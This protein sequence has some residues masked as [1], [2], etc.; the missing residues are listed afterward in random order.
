MCVCVCLGNV[1]EKKNCRVCSIA[2]VTIILVAHACIAVRNLTTNFVLFYETVF[3]II[4][5]A[6]KNMG[7]NFILHNFRDT[8]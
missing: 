4:Y 5:K 7:T 2:V 1:R 8:V 3:G 6:S